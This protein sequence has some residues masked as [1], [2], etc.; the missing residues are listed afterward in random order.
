[1]QPRSVLKPTADRPARGRVAPLGAK[2]GSALGGRLSRSNRSR[3]PTRTAM[4][5]PKPH[6]QVMLDSGAFSS[7]TKQEPIAIGASIAFV[8][9]VEPYLWQHVGLDVIPGARGRPRT[10]ADVEAAAAASHRNF[11]T[12]QA[13]GLRPLPTFH[14]G[15]DI[16][17]LERMLADGQNYIGVSSA[18]NY[19][20]AIQQAW[21]DIVFTVLTDCQGRP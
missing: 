12:M 9:E 5:K 17:W 21:L 10:F 6:V 15:E 16:K 8:R 2:A 18:K 1:C 14:Q 19:P 7:W 13:A 3:Q 20:R 11:K 4:P